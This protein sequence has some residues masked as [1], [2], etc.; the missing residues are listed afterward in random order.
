MREKTEACPDLLAHGEDYILHAVLD[1]IVDN[2][3]PVMET[4]LSE[5]EAI[6]DCILKRELHRTRSSGSTCCGATS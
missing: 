6:E 2:Y 4:V 1:F 5:V 3:G